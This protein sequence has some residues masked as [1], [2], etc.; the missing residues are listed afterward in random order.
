LK[1]PVISQVLM[2]KA[3]VTAIAACVGLLASEATS[4]AAEKFQELTGT[5]IRARFTGVEMTD[6]VHFADVFGANGGLRTYSM[7]SKKDGKWR[8]ERDELCVDRGKDDGGCYQVWISGR[9]WNSDATVCPPLSRESCSGPQPA[10]DFA[11]Q[12]R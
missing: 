5:Q 4:H 1:V 12:L 10:T 8:I 9:T 3:I 7:G 6:N 2:M 11:A